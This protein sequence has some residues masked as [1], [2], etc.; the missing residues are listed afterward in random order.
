MVFAVFAGFVVALVAGHYLGDSDSRV[1][2]ELTR[3]RFSKP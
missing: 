2:S 3:S 1:S